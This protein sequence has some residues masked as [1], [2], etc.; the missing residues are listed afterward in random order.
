VAEGPDKILKNNPMQ[1]GAGWAEQNL[2]TTPCK[3]L[4]EGPDKTEE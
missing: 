4:A 1:C 3:G 2:K